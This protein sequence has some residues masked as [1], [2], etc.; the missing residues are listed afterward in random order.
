MKKKPT[1]YLIAIFVLTLVTAELLSTRKV[2][3]AVLIVTNTNNSGAGSLR[4][5]IIDEHRRHVNMVVC[6]EDYRK[7]KRCIEHLP[8]GM[9]ERL[10]SSIVL[11]SGHEFRRALAA[12]RLVREVVPRIGHDCEPRSNVNSRRR[13]E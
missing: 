1:Y 4:Q 12:T 10:A 8:L 2:Q 5:A 13:G 6:E 7:L 9:Q 11:Q 3:G